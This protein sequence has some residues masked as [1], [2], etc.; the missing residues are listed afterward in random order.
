MFTCLYI[1][2][3]KYER[4]SRGFQQGEDAG[5]RRHLSEYCVPRNIVDIS[6]PPPQ[7]M[8]LFITCVACG[9]EQDTGQ[10][11]VY[12]VQYSTVQ[13]STVYKGGTSWGKGHLLLHQ[14]VLA[15]AS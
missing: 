3:N 8:V 15:G 11:Q 14:V 13:Y 12:S 6:T 10:C 7:K 1:I 9:A 2:I 4:G 5:K